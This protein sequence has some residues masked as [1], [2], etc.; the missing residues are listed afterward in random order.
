MAH[1]AVASKR[2]IQRI[3]RLDSH[4]LNRMAAKLIGP[5][6]K[7]AIMNDVTAGVVN[8]AGLLI[9]RAGHDSGD[10]RRSGLSH[11]A[12]AD[13]PRSS[14]SPSEAQTW[15]VWPVA[16]SL[17]LRRAGAGCGLAWVSRTAGG[18][19]GGNPAIDLHAD[20]RAPH[21]P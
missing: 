16:G 9:D 13:C 20:V 6:I 1:V 3:V 12:L 15:V 19:T 10:S 11:S 8:A 14:F 4:A 2:L 17:R 18:D 7:R 21:V 5:S